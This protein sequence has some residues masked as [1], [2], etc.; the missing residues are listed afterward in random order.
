MDNILEITFIEKNSKPKSD[1][2]FYIENN[3]NGLKLLTSKTDVRKISKNFKFLFPLEIYKVFS[4]LRI[5]E[6]YEN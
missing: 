5:H 1:L 2:F 4:I 3:E 6:P